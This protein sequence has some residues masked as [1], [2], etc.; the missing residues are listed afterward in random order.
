MK[1]NMKQGHCIFRAENATDDT[2]TLFFISQQKKMIE[3]PNKAFIEECLN[4]ECPKKDENGNEWKIQL[5]CNRCGGN[6]NIDTKFKTCEP[7][8]GGI[9][10]KKLV[11][12]YWWNNDRQNYY[13]DIN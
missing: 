9:L 13:Y 12:Y 5:I 10:Q 4:S 2:R 1:V 7:S 3:K 8:C 11:S 6:F